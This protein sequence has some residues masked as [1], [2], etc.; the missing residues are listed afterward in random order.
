VTDPQ[1]A[2]PPVIET[3]GLAKR[4]RKVTALT[5]CTVAALVTW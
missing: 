1:D 4:Y 3:R 2:A 5:D